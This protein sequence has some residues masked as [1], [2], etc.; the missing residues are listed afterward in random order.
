MT[1]TNR[2]PAFGSDQG[3]PSDYAVEVQFFDL[4]D[5]PEARVT[6]PLA[7]FA[8]QSSPLGNKTPFGRWVK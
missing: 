4:T 1:D 5:R 7:L 3:A 8:D 2:D 6:L